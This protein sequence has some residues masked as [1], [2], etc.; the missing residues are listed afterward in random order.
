MECSSRNY[1]YPS[2]FSYIKSALILQN[3]VRRTGKG[4]KKKNYFVGVYVGFGLVIEIGAKFCNN[5]GCLAFTALYD[6]IANAKEKRIKEIR[7]THPSII[8]L[9]GTKNI[10]IKRI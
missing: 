6:F 4:P 2:T 10:V 9:Y 3:L 5:S 8:Y 1:L 7:N